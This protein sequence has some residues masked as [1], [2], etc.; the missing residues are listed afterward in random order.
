MNEKDVVIGETYLLETDKL[1]DGVRWSSNFPQILKN[2][3][4]NP[5]QAD[6]EKIIVTQKSDEEPDLFYVEFDRFKGYPFEIGGTLLKEI[7]EEKTKC[8]CDITNL[9]RLGCRCGNFKLEMTKK[10]RTYNK[11][12]RAWD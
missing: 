1:P 5:K 10:G 4:N 12:T 2:V 6:G 9:T 11:H 7:P 3:F 8:K